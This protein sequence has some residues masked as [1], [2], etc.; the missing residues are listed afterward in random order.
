VNN[1][2]TILKNLPT[3]ALLQVL[4]SQDIAKIEFRSK[5]KLS[6]LVMVLAQA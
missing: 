6:S 1:A 3:K 2:G 4:F 5:N